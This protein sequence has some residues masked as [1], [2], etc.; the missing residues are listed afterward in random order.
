[1]ISTNSD[2]PAS[3]LEAARDAAVVCDLSPLSLLGITGPDAASFLQGQLSTDVPGLAEGAASHTSFNSPQ[4]RMLANFVLWREGPAEFRALVPGDIV[5]AIRK[6]LSM[7]VLRSKVVVADRTADFVRLG[8]GGPRAKAALEG[9]LANAPASMGVA[10][11]GDA[12]IIG[13][14]GP[15]YLVVAPT[16]LAAGLLDRLGQHALRAP[17]PAWEWLTI[18]AGVPVVTAPVQNQIVAQAANWDVLGGLDFR[19]GCYTGQ[20]IIARMQYLGRL[21]ERLFAFHTGRAPVTAGTRLYG[22]PFG[23]Q[24]CGLVVNAAPAPAGGTDMLAVA[25]L[26]A[27]EAGGLRLEAPDGPLLSPLPLPYE[28]PPPA[29]PRGRV[30]APA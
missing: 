3:A 10:R 29:P 15:R 13:L 24:A 9:G 17:Y 11:A 12:A 22:P 23:E 19:K 16:D 1:M 30:G 27:V 18:R 8:V 2:P 14:P 7:Y 6:R 5:D 21:K 26:A 20:E 25:Q 4:G 28:V